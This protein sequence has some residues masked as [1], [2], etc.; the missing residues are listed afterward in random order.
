MAN[1]SRADARYALNPQNASVRFRPR[2]SLSRRVISTLI[3][4]RSGG[5]DLARVEHLQ[6]AAPRHDVGAI[7]VAADLGDAGRLVLAVA[8]D[9]DQA[10]IPRIDRVAEGADQPGAIAAIPLVPD[11]PDRRE[12]AEQVGRP[13]R[14]AVVDHQDVVGEAE[15][16]REDRLQVGLF[17]IDRDRCQ[18]SHGRPR[19]GRAGEREGTRPYSRPAVLKPRHS[20]YRQGEVND[21]AEGGPRRH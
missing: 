13:V 7:E 19:S 16:L 8:I 14:R 20:S 17:V 6:V 1:F 12:R 4:R 21:A 2:H 15:D 18:D 9:G 3:L 10:V 11:H 5:G